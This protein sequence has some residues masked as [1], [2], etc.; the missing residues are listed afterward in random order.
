MRLKLDWRENWSNRTKEY[1]ESSR[2]WEKRIEERRR[3]RG[4]ENFL[5]I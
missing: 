3:R 2:G 5:K 4:E 1:L